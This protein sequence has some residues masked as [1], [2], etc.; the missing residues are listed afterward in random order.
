MGSLVT[1][2]RADPRFPEVLGTTGLPSSSSMSILDFAG[3]IER[4]L[5]S[6][7]DAK[8]FILKQLGILYTKP[9]EPCA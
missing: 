5:V 9:S 2:P 6:S 1:P 4:I 3:S 8:S 7:R